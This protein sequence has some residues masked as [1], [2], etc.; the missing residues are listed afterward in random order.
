M[1]CISSAKKRLRIACHH[2]E[3]FQEWNTTKKITK[4]IWV[5]LKRKK[6]I[7]KN[8]MLRQAL[9]GGRPVSSICTDRTVFKILKSLFSYSVRISQTL[10]RNF[11]NIY[12]KKRGWSI[13]YQL[14]GCWLSS[15]NVLLLLEKRERKKRHVETEGVLKKWYF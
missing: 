10:G 5:R 9:T 13:L 1:K 15:R 2:L 4:V 8:V 14:L 12:Y 7:Y 6:Y 11:E 3:S